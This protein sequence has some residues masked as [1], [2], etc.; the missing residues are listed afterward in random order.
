M[1]EIPRVALARHEHPYPPPN[2]KLSKSYQYDVENNNPRLFKWYFYLIETFYIKSVISRISSKI[3]LQLPHASAPGIPKA[4][5]PIQKHF[6]PDLFIPLPKAQSNL[7][8]GIDQILNEFYEFNQTCRKD[9]SPLQ[10]YTLD[11]FYLFFRINMNFVRDSARNPYAKIHS[12]S[13]YRQHTPEELDLTDVDNVLRIHKSIP[14]SIELIERT[15]AH[16]SNPINYY[17]QTDFLPRGII[18][19]SV[20]SAAQ[21]LMYAYRLEESDIIRQYIVMAEGIFTIPIIWG[22]WETSEI[23]RNVLHNFLEEHPAKKAKAATGEPSLS[24]D[25]SVCTYDNGLFDGVDFSD[26][27]SFITSLLPTI[28]HAAI[29]QGP[30]RPPS[31]PAPAPAPSS[32]SNFINNPWLTGQ[33]PWMQDINQIL[34]NS[35]LLSTPFIDPLFPSQHQ[36]PLQQQQQQQQPSHPPQPPVETIPPP[37][38][39]MYR[40]GEAAAAA[41]VAPPPPPPMYSS[42][43]L[44]G[45][46]AANLPTHGH[47]QIFVNNVSKMFF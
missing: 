8:E 43:S 18:V 27:S 1:E 13:L 26:D 45:G 9:W 20:D 34:F 11:L 16:L 46:P 47:N 14:Q 21:V 24:P 5:P 7:E 30:I 22:N 35:D 41:V 6:K 28:N 3:I 19:S 38:Q 42:I 25:S 32:A 15:H 4:P 12:F 39:N 33:E 10:A 23:L 2:I 31:A 17:E 36:Q 37:Y 44:V 40:Y 29:V